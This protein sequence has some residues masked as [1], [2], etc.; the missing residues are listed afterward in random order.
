MLKDYGSPFNSVWLLK[1]FFFISD[2]T[3]CIYC[4][5]VDFPNFVSSSKLCWHMLKGCTKSSIYF[6]TAAT[7]LL[8]FFDTKYKKAYLKIK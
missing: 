3:E 8:G 1:H 5:L 4:F 6:C 7:N 2:T